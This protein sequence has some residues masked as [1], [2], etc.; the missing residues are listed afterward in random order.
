MRLTNYYY[1]AETLAALGGPF[2]FFRLPRELRDK[3]YGYLLTFKDKTTIMSIVRGQ[4]RFRRH[5]EI[6][7]ADDTSGL[8]GKQVE[9]VKLWIHPLFRT[10][11]YLREEASEYFYRANH[12]V[13][14]NKAAFDIELCRFILPKN[15]FCS[16]RNLS[17]PL[18]ALGYGT[19]LFCSRV[20]RLEGLRNLNIYASWKTIKK[21]NAPDCLAVE[22]FR[23][24]VIDHC[25]VPQATSCFI[26]RQNAAFKESLARFKH[27]RAD[28]VALK[29]PEY[30]FAV[31][32]FIFRRRTPEL[33]AQDEAQEVAAIDDLITVARKEIQELE[34]AKK[35][36]QLENSDQEQNGGLSVFPVETEKT[37]YPI[38]TEILRDE[39]FHTHATHKLPFVFHKLTPLLK[40]NVF[41]C[42]MTDERYMPQSKSESALVF[43]LKALKF[44]DPA[45]CEKELC[46]R[47]TK[48]T[49]RNEDYED[50]S[51]WVSDEDSDGN[52]EVEVDSE[53]E[54]LWMG[55][56]Y[57]RRLANRI[58]IARTVKVEAKLMTREQVERNIV[59]ILAKIDKWKD[60]L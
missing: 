24:L 35:A 52:T 27:F 39:R 7:V 40:I 43:R 18:T 21:E 46:L 4:A 13:L 34:D 5:R 8:D 30:R 50:D 53:E 3:V 23:S 14:P 10:S 48:T 56:G 6:V 20:F 58:C 12:F 19:K 32:M 25:V 26:A 2:K 31:T 33:R 55:S 57:N 37:K 36:N 16:I 41:D 54:D 51:D 59:R 42:P 49:L 9:R 60:I 45:K 28:I 11:K 44:K 22:A 38:T 1:S 47:D 17:I 29:L 15:F